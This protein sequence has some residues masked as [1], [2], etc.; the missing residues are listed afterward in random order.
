MVHFYAIVSLMHRI[1]RENIML[2][3]LSMRN[4]LHIN[5]IVEATGA[6]EATIRRDFLRM[7]ENNKIRRIRGGIELLSDGET[8][9]SPNMEPPFLNRMNI[10]CEQKR[11][12]AKA[13]CEMINEGE[14]IMIDGGTTPYYM[15][16][17][18]PQFS[19]N[20][21]T[22]SL[23]VA[24]HLIKYSNCIVS[25]PEGNIDPTSLL[26]LNNLNPDPFLN[27][28][29]KKVFMGIEGITADRL[30]NSEPRFIQTKM[31]MMKHSEELI[32]L[33]DETKF[34]KVGLLTLC[35]TEKVSKFITT[36]LVDSKIVGELRKKGIEVITV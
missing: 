34:G 35:E 17:F 21:V 12:I 25:L 28:N 1:E 14:V 10:N 15:V 16:E 32:I 7:E 30:T 8:S 29:A 6:S 5:E 27:Y 33:A 18:I 3:L 31:A 2:R 22:H 24:E 11:K 20:V 23:A 9:N 13:A 19:F 26:L 36:S 4:Y